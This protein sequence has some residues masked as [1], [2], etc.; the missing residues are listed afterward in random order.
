LS[1]DMTNGVNRLL[2]SPVYLMELANSNKT[3]YRPLV[4]GCSA[5]LEIRGR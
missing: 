3:L 4:M 2:E 5:K 1:L